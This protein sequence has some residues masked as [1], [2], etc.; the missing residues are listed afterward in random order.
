MYYTVIYINTKELYIMSEKVMTF[1]VDQKQK[2]EFEKY[3]KSIDLTASQLL[4]QFVRETV[5]KNT[6]KGKNNG[7]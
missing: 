2:Y 7:R 6:S 4:R 1:R 3:A 5:E